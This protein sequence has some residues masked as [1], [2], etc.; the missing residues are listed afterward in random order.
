MPAWV[1]HVV[2]SLLSGYA[3][4]LDCGSGRRG[5]AT[6]AFFVYVPNDYLELKPVYVLSGWRDKKSG[7]E[8][9]RWLL[10][11]CLLSA[12]I[13]GKAYDFQVDGIFYSKNADG[14]SVGVV[15]EIYGQNSTYTGDVVIPASVTY[16]GTTYAVTSINENAFYR[17]TITSLILPQSI[18]Y[19]GNA[20]MKSCTQ[21]THIELPGA[22]ETIGISAFAR[23]GLT[24]ITIPA[25]VSAMLYNKN[26]I[27][28]Y[29][30]VFEGCTALTTAV[31]EEGSKLTS[32]PE[33]AFAGCSALSSITLPDGL[34]SIGSNA[35][36][37]S[38]GNAYCT[39]L[40]G[41]TLPETVQVIGDGAFNNSGLTSLRIPQNVTSFGQFYACPN[42]E[43]IIVEEG[44]GNAFSSYAFEYLRKL[45]T[46]TFPSTMTEIPSYMF[47]FC[48]QL[49][50]VNL[51]SKLETIGAGAFRNCSA[52]ETL[53]LP[54]SVTYIGEWALSTINTINIEDYDQ[55]MNLAL[56]ER[57]FNSN[58]NF[59]H[60][61][62][63]GELVTDYRLPVDI[64]EI[65]EFRLYRNTDI[66]TLTIP[67]NVTSIGKYSFRECTSLQTVTFAEGSKLKSIR[68][69]SFCVC[70]SLTE[71][72][73]PN[74][75]E[76]IDDYAFS[77]C[78]NLTSVTFGTGIKSIGFGA[79]SY[80][81]KITNVDIADLENWCNVIFDPDNY[82]TH[83]TGGLLSSD[84]LESNPLY[85][86]KK[87]IA[88]GLETTELTISDG[89]TRI[90]E[91]TFVGC[92]G[93]TKV[94]IPSSVKEI[95]AAA[96]YGCSG[97]LN[98]VWKGTPTVDKIGD[99]AF[100]NCTSLTSA[101]I[102]NT[103]T[104]AGANLFQGCTALS[105]VQLSSQQ[106]WIA[107]YTF[108]G[109][110]KLAN[111]VIPNGVKY[112]YHHAFM[113]CTSLKTINIPASVKHIGSA[114][115]SGCTG[116]KETHITDLGAW[117]GIYLENGVEYSGG[118][119]AGVEE[120]R[121]NPVRYSHNLYLDDVLLTKVNIPEG[122]TNIEPGAFFYLYGVD[123]A[124]IPTTI[125]SIGS[126]A[127]GCSTIKTLVCQATTPPVLWRYKVHSSNIL[128]ETITHFNPS[129]ISLAVQA[130][131]HIYVKQG[132]GDAYKE[133]W[134]DYADIIEEVDDEF[135]EGLKRNTDPIDFAD[136][137]VKQLCVANWDTNSDGEL[138]YE[139]AA[140]VTDIGEAFK[141]SAITSFDE[142]R[143][144]TGLDAIPDNAFFSCSNLTSVTLPMN[145]TAIGDHSLQLTQIARLDIPRRVQ[146]IGN[147]TTTG[148]TNLTA[149]Q[150]NAENTSFDSRNDCNAVIATTTN[151]LIIGC[152]TTTIPS[153]V[154]SIGASAFAQQSLLTE[155]LIPATV[156]SIEGYAFDG[157]P[158][159]E[160]VS[161]E[162]GTPLAIS[163]MTFRNCTNA[164]LYVPYGTKTAYEAAT[165]WQDFNEI[166]EVSPESVSIAMA[167]GSG[168]AR[169][170]IGYSSRYGLDF[171]NVEKVKAW[172]AIGYSDDG[173]V[174][175][176]HINVVPPF[177]GLYLTT[178]EPGITAEVPT[179]TR[180]Y[181]YAN[182]LVPVVETKT[183]DPTE[184]IDGIEYTNLIVGTLNG[185]P[186]FSFLKSTVSYGPNKSVLRIPTKYIPQ[187]AVN[188]RSM[189]IK[190][191]DEEAT[192]INNTSL[193]KQDDS[194][195][196]S[197][198]GY[199]MDGNTYA[200]GA[201][202][203]G[204]Y[205]SNG[206]K[207][208]IK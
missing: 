67:A 131:D 62:L 162:W 138:S 33:N 133:A 58:S 25:N 48:S 132:C 1:L 101:T 14:I 157:C 171:T 153:S 142:L 93:L 91:V 83:V 6:H 96:F 180:E 192:P 166:V 53:D 204:I 23:S 39:A 103:V 45:K 10:L 201:L 56:E 203:R 134:S 161:V 106:T 55:W 42:L 115:F 112:I 72:H 15:C 154:K 164:T 84:G 69:R 95:G 11:L 32:L 199:K 26:I 111:I 108:N 179:T 87:V 194:A 51:P 195:I 165:G 205:I 5:T 124:I 54:K 73:L 68:E 46:V 168:A 78:S 159:L 125:D 98:I 31:F 13:D 3:R 85:F 183:V 182:L 187:Q 9:K 7:R 4:A 184:T 90:G 107:E 105:S 202:P 24:S 18:K 61:Y 158:G 169:Y 89:A 16:E 167:T 77:S 152:K 136:A 88:N 41:I 81:S 76:V 104:S 114:C 82:R 176:S 2:R 173:R 130:F 160:S 189:G 200:K 86:A 63:N 144:F 151:K 113:N 64:T 196:Y 126:N 65:P 119:T 163:A 60:V 120:N 188:A 59:G 8:M 206:K 80:D 116:L 145:I 147:Y 170:A 193:E 123:M 172:V 181:Y 79:F 20:A 128:D 110:T 102:P 37:R 57:V 99:G 190:F 100:A 27:N 36:G 148:C 185:K 74:S 150:V 22:L 208:I 44:V 129:E 141:Y 149:I 71:I 19:I 50:T 97:L 30:G 122:I 29:A 117:C 177:T 135:I 21:L 198:L 178:D 40:T 17:S 143:F 127:F 66:K 207:I 140:A 52:L 35:F 146:T 92:A 191:L 174:I 34:V 118:G 47:S 49:T 12:I 186:T 109:C 70:S 156:T 175:V 155:M 139:E 38:S 197:L 94:T 121:C 137:T 43:E 28:Y 75:L